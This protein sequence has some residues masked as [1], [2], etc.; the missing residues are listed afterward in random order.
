MSF[1]SKLYF[2]CTVKYRAEWP[3]ACPGLPP[4]PE[5]AAP[6]EADGIRILST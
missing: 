2:G 3:G 5:T 4:P 6:F 1:L